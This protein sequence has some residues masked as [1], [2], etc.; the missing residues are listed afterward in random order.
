MTATSSPSLAAA[1]A[2]LLRDAARGERVIAGDHLHLDAGLL[3]L[4]HRD[5][6]LGA[7][8]IDHALQAEKGEPLAHMIVVQVRSWSCAT[9][10][11]AKAST[12]RPRAAICSTAA[13]TA[14]GV[15]RREFAVVAERVRAALQQALDGALLEND[16]RLAVAATVQRGHELVLGLEG[17]HVQPRMRARACRRGQA[18]LFRG[19]DE[20]GFRRVALDL[21]PVAVAHELRIV[22]EQAGEQRLA[23]GRVLSRA[24]RAGPSESTSPHG[25]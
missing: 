22:V 6:G 15:E 19:D 3:A 24:R 23:Q 4:A 10:R 17:N 11:R 9:S 7:R 21:E 18:R 1:Q 16:A 25:S 12:R 20:R 13:W 5:D 2:E 8:R 14:R